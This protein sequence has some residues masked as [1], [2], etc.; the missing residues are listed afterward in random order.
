MSQRDAAF[1]HYSP[2]SSLSPPPPCGGLQKSLQLPEVPP[3]HHP[4]CAEGSAA[5]AAG[6]EAGLWIQ[7]KEKQADQGREKSKV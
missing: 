6:G 4:F 1:I 2:P 3:D 7:L 5:A